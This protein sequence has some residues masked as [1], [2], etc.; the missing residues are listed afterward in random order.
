MVFYNS[1]D[2][3]AER[4]SSLFISYRKYAVS[5]SH[6][7]EGRALNATSITQMSV[8]FIRYCSMFI[9]VCWIEAVKRGLYRLSPLLQAFL[10]LCLVR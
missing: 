5:E 10:H 1:L 8:T 2:H 7:Q 3:T 6:K 4:T 9:T